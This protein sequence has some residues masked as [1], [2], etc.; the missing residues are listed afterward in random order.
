MPSSLQVLGLLASCL[1][2][3]SATGTWEPRAFG[4]TFF[5]GPPSSSSNYI[6]SLTYD[7]DTVPGVPTGYD[8]G[9]ATDSI[10]VSPWVGIEASETDRS[11]T[12][13]QPL[14]NW[15]PNQE[16]TGCAGAT[17]EEWCVAA[18]TYMPGTHRYTLG[19]LLKL[20]ECVLTPSV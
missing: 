5:I 15:Q 8:I 18:S 19:L 13:V 9:S 7:M 2:G 14:F 3:V 10:W 16:S 11:G 1:A 6:A 4:N 12:L 17:A 20:C